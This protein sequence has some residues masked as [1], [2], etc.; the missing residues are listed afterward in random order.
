MPIYEYE[1]RGC[2]HRFE[3]LLLPSTVPV[4]PSCNGNDL[5]RAI[6]LFAVSSDGTRQQALSD[7]RKRAARVQ[8][9]KAHAEAEYERDHQH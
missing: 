8:R 9:D 1:C 6:S 3:F 2:G 7:G 5:E 4:C